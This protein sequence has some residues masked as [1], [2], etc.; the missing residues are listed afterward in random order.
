[1]I[2][3]RTWQDL[4]AHSPRAAVELLEDM[5]E[6]RSFSDLRGAL[7]AGLAADRPG[8]LVGAIR[9]F[10]RKYSDWTFAEGGAVEK[11]AQAW[12]AA[13]DPSQEVKL[14]DELLVDMAVRAEGPVRSLG[15]RL[16]ARMLEAR[17]A[18]LTAIDIE[19]LALSISMA[20]GEKDAHDVAR[21]ALWSPWGGELVGRAFA[22]TSGPTLREKV[23]R[24]ALEGANA[25]V[26]ARYGKAL[27]TMVAVDRQHGRG[28]Y[29]W[30]TYAM[31]GAG[32]PVSAKAQRDL[33]QGKTTQVF[34]SDQGPVAWLPYMLLHTMFFR[35]SAF[36][37]A[38]AKTEMRRVL[39][40]LLQLGV[41]FDAHDT[42]QG[43]PL[44]AAVVQKDYGV[45]KLLIDY[46]ADPRNGVDPA[47]TGA[48]S[49]KTH[50]GVWK[51]IAGQIKELAARNGPDGELTRAACETRDVMAAA[52]A[53][54]AG[55]EALGQPRKA[56]ARVSA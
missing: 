30:L 33:Q 27:E 47:A 18:P 17:T 36:D 49:W 48:C 31:L 13:L 39:D 51:L 7:A 11:F 50:G 10:E 43:T 32:V 41:E 35:G 28:E 5:A 38:T 34:A 8:A 2:A 22:V 9:A 1:M 21:A 46:G 25:A 19:K 3:K 14:L 12:C 53:R 54:Y 56:N 52:V 37:D 40:R 42:A 45:A 4:V 29:L 23:L 55:L 15:A 26:F 24:V 20:A 6:Q 16:I 44:R